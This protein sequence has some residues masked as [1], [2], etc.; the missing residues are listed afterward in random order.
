MFRDQA[1]MLGSVMMARGLDMVYGGGSIGLMGVIADTILEGGGKVIGVIPE[2]LV[3]KEVDHKSVTEMHTVST[4]HERKQLMADLA[5]GFIAMP[6]G[7]GT[8][9]ELAEILTWVQLGLV[10]KPVGLLNVRDFFSPLRNQ[11]D[12]MVTNEFLTAENRDILII[13]EDSH[14]LLDRMAAFRPPEVEKW[15]K[16]DQI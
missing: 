2:F 13:E 3:E 7:F 8:L 6:G 16:R 15:L 14:K 11:F 9:D 12:V 10:R 4:M 1:A 5:D